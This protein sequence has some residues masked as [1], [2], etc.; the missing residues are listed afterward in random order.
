MSLDPREGAASAASGPPVRLSRESARRIRRRLRTIAATFERALPQLPEEAEGT[1]EGRASEWL[2]D[3]A[4]LLAEALEQLRTGLSADFL[5]ELPQLAA[6]PRAGEPRI[7]ATARRL[8]TEEDGRFDVERAQTVLV[9]DTP[10]SPLRIAELWA[11]PLMLRLVL[12]ENLAAAADALAR[13][14]IDG[15]PST[16]ERRTGLPPPPPPENV[17]ALVEGLR[18]IAAVH[19]ESFVE[20]ASRVHRIL[21]GDPAGIY[22]RMDFE[23]R[24]RYRKAVEQIAR[25]GRQDEEAVAA[26]AVEQAA[27]G[28]PHEREGHVGTYLRGPARRELER[29]LGV[30]PP[31][32]A[33]VRRAL[34]DRATA[35]YLGTIAIV[36]ATAL[37][38]LVLPLLEEGSLAAIVGAVVVGLIPGHSLA[39]ELV[40]WVATHLVRPSTLPKL[41]PDIGI[42]PDAR[43]AVVVPVL[44]AAERD[45]ED[46]LAQV[47]L[48]YFGNPDP[49]LVYCLLITYADAAAAE[50]PEDA[51][52]LAA[53]RTGVERMNARHAAGPPAF[54]LLD[55]PRRWN[56]AQGCWMGPE[57][58]RGKLEAFNRIV[59]GGEGDL[60]FVVGDRDRLR[61]VRYVIT[62]DA[63]TLLPQGAARRLVATLAHP[64]NR[65]VFDEGSGVVEGYTVLQPRIEVRPT[66]SERSAFARIF[67]RDRGLDLYTRAVSDVYQD[68]FGEGS[69]AGKGIYDVEA[70]DRS[71]RGVVPENRLLS[72]D[73]FE[74]VHGRAG[75]VSDVVVFEDYPAHVLTYMRRL[76][77]WV[78][79]DWQIA[80][81]LLPRVPGAAGVRRNRLSVL[82]RWKILD[83]LRRSVLATSLLLLML[84]G[85]LVLPGPIVW[86]TA[87]ALGPLAAPVVL[88]AASAARPRGR[89]RRERIRLEGPRAV[90]AGAAR[91][92][93]A[94]VLLPY[95]AWMETDAAV[96]T[97]IRCT[98]TRRNLLEWT[99]AAHVGHRIRERGGLR[100]TMAAMAPAVLAMGVGFAAVAAFRPAAI[101]Y[102]AP[103]LLLWLVSPVIAYRVSRPPAPE[104]SGIESD[105]LPELRRLARRTWGFFE[106][107]VGPDEQWLPPDNF[108]EDPN[109]VLAR[110]TSPTNIGF[111][112][113]STLTAYDLAFLPVTSLV[114]RL[115]NTLA[116]L[117]S[118][119]RY[120]GHFLNWYETHTLASLEPRYVSTVDS[121]NLAGALLAVA[122][123][124]REA[125]HDPLPQ[126]SADGLLA[127]IEVLGEVLEEVGLER[128]TIAEGWRRLLDEVREGISANRDDVGR[129]VRF[130]DDLEARLVPRLEE[131]LLE[132]LETEAPNLTPAA[133]ARL[134]SWLAKGRMQVA[135]AREE[136]GVLA[137]WLRWDAPNVI[138]EVARLA[139]RDR[140]PLAELPDFC[141]SLDADLERR[142]A[143][144]DPTVTGSG[145]AL[146]WIQAARE[147]TRAAYE[148]AR[149]LRGE[150]DSIAVA[151]ER[152]VEDMEF[153]FLYDARRH[154]FHIGYNIAA[155]R[156][157]P[158]YY[159]LLASEARLASLIAI[160]KG[161]VPA[162]HWV[163]LGRPFRRSDGL[164]ALLSWG[165][166]MFE[167]LL[168]GTLTNTP[169]HSLLAMGCRTAVRLQRRFGQRYGVPWGVSE[170]A[171]FELDAHGTYQYRA[172]GVPGLALRRDAGERLVIAPYAS[173]LAL[174]MVPRE[175]MHNLGRIAALG[176]IGP[177]G[178]YEAIDFGPAVRLARHVPR[179]VR[180]YMAH[181]QGMILV[182]IGNAATDGRMRTRFHADPRI[183][184]VELLLHEHI[185]GHALAE[186]RLPV[187]KLRRLPGPEVRPALPIRPIDVRVWPQVQVLSNGRF[188]SMVTARGG[189]GIRW[190]G[191]SIT[192]WAADPSREVHGMWIYLRD[193]DTGAVWSATDAPTYAGADRQDILFGLDA[194]EFRRWQGGIRSALTIGV[195]HDAPVEIRRLTIANDSDTRRRLSVTSYGEVA[196]APVAE[197]RR[198]PAFAKLFVESRYLTDEEVLLFHRRAPRPGEPGL[199]LAHGALADTGAV[200]TGQETDRAAFL[201]RGRTIRAP[202]AQSDGRPGRN[203][204]ERRTPLDPVLVLHHEVELRA[205]E[206]V[207]IDLITAVGESA[208]EALAYF[209]AHRTRG[210]IER[211]FDGARLRCEREIREL[212][213]TPQETGMLGEFLSAMVYPY[214][215]PSA[216]ISGLDPASGRVPPFRDTLWSLGVSGD[217]PI[218]VLR[219]QDAEDAKPLLSPLVRM[220]AYWRRAGVRMDL[221]VLD[222]Q[223]GDYTEPVRHDLHEAMTRVGGLHWLNRSGGVFYVPGGRLDSPSRAGVLGAAGLLI[224]SGGGPLA[225]QLAAT[226][227]RPPPLPP[228]VPLT[229]TPPQTIETPRL[230]RTADLLFDNGLGGFD[231]DDGA[232]V[233]FLEPGRTTPAPWSN[234]VANPRFGFLATESGLGFTWS[235]NSGEHRLTPWN[236]DPVTDP[237]GEVLYIRDEETAEFWSPTPGP[238]PAAGGYEVRHAPGSTT[239]R[240]AS[241]GL[242]QQVLASIAPD[243]PVKIV[244]VRLRNLQFRQRRLTLTYYAEWVLGTHRRILAAH[245][246][247]EFDERLQAILA[248]QTFAPEFGGRVAF[249]TSSESAH[250]STGDR[251]E[252]FGALDN[253]AEPAALRRIG[254]AGRFGARLD[255]CGALQVHVDLA[256][257]AEHTV[258]FLLG[259]GADRAEAAQ[260]V[261]RF[262]DPATAEE[263]IVAERDTWTRHLDRIQVRTPLPGLDLM[264]NHWLPYQALSC[265]VWGRSGFYQSSGAYGFRD[266]LQDVTSLF[267]SAPDLARA[268]ILEAARHQ[269]HEGDVLHWWHPHSGAGV[270]TR[271]SDDLLWLPFVTAAYV[272][273]TGD[274]AILDRPVPFLA[275]DPLAEGEL[276]RYASFPSSETPAPLLEHCLRAIWRGST[277]GE[278]GLPLIG[279]GDWNDAM[280]RI[281]VEG[282]GE[283]VWLAWF[284][285]AILLRFAPLCEARG[286]AAC[287]RRL[288]RLA[289]EY[290][291]AAEKNAWDGAWYRRAYFDDGSPVG[292]AERDECR[293][294]SLTQSWAVLSGGADPARARKAMR[295][296][297]QHLVR[298]ADGLVLLLTPPF[299]RSLP[300]PGY[301]RAYPPGIRENGGQYTHAAIWLAWA[302]AELGDGDEAGKLLDLLIPAHRAASAEDAARYRVEP[303]VIAAD[304]YGVP[305]HTGRGGWTWY[306]GSAGW[307]YRLAVER[308]LGIRRD[309]GR[310]VIDPCIPRSWPG[311]EATVRDATTLYRIGVRN[312]DGVC[313]GVVA[314]RLDGEPLPSNHL[315]PADGGTHDVEVQLG[316]EEGVPAMRADPR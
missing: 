25:W 129:W 225:E 63:D 40:N 210:R 183:A 148:R 144:I 227:H 238:A 196:L 194:V 191:R 137:P 273:A 126:R 178:L 54:L 84:V 198:H 218:V 286:D 88:S 16:R 157:D 296:A 89:L 202:Y 298:A 311:F 205:G 90:A 237:P 239:F 290:A 232:Y 42:P 77:R 302:F 275:G 211:A 23:T 221:I 120:R 184:A 310:L 49:E 3:N 35:W 91:W 115:S 166:S 132:A 50:V 168:P 9:G 101:P 62:L 158:S 204:D 74:G 5:R 82:S 146:A 288:R 56:L 125:V 173:A 256:P 131:S 1:P 112:L 186:P 83:N 80:A 161:D 272:R 169:A 39:V 33:R 295:A 152:L 105:D 236:N 104:P 160:A 44:V 64:L 93:L 197:F 242:D 81:W 280:D 315:P 13:T 111:L 179:I 122:A 233:I 189:G 306:T 206:E 15:G 255:P 212:Q 269:F 38:I 263:A 249:L 121:G 190:R 193:R 139:P 110:R 30:R 284:L 312:P 264:V 277:A 307:L 201:G 308:V 304:V 149:E 301:I 26:A 4:H 230:E 257:G 142:A 207:G 45:V 94:L 130:L 60:R 182:A 192:P 203:E 118:L 187:T 127:T 289:G 219:V 164:P 72:H 228:F 17:G 96:R 106:T 268:Q 128:V 259:D 43:T 229:A 176:G 313:R 267:A 209:R 216:A 87:A 309:S 20:G 251:I 170:S 314:V 109:G 171:Y 46:L 293:I 156:L 36:T 271:C 199:W 107:F 188:G 217:L 133:L 123:G 276:E 224:D 195:A 86:W 248:R 75:L 297:R 220:H 7:Y 70:F 98:I 53:L 215:A 292:S 258:Y 153:D 124:C 28:R 58:K 154:L 22:S 59:L 117:T 34:S 85:W 231:S 300:S 252:F 135:A 14:G 18:S 150:L 253:I 281:G 278:R 291:A 287:A 279:T 99:S 134:R 172:F 235:Q 283:S 31:L 244:R 261:G 24:D 240:H 19:W 8:I 174:E 97:L 180:N 67:Q 260:R 79:G 274:A 76:H 165:G 294:D 69:Y 299:D 52:L 57:R 243:E 41:D 29:S 214:R 223:A 177:Y 113:L 245:L 102:A 61:G 68:L 143:E 222:E 285:H 147:G 241:H 265:R 155:G 21:S 200:P 119:E 303:Y 250:G 47:E 78:R 6:G 73:L 65:A 270:R 66:A 71:L 305:P 208:A 162:R 136:I 140:V 246:V 2:L 10:G 12:L 266:Q 282:R 100:Y 92:A 151:A 95:R 114:A 226:R 213:L 138:A 141:R 48:N 55:R 103:L 108:Q 51:R 37:A 185:P 32:T 163:H 254:L 234:V 262:R 247:T 145:E 159:D 316:Q 27:R 175:V 11:L 167:F 181:H 116:T